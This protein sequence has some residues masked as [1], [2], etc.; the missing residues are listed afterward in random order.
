MGLPSDVADAFE[1]QRGRAT[2]DRQRES[3]KQVI[4]QTTH[5]LARFFLEIDANHKQFQVARKLREQGQIRLDRARASFEE[6]KADTSVDRLLDAIVQYA[7]AV[8]QEAQ[9]KCSYNTSLA[10]LE[11]AKGTLLAERKILVV[12]RPRESAAKAAGVASTPRLVESPPTGIF[13][14]D[15]DVKPAAFAAPADATS[16]PIAPKADSPAPSGRVIRYDIALEGGPVPVQ[17]KGT[18]S[19]GAPGGAERADVAARP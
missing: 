7:D 6:G 9:Y 3:L 8:V 17:L 12:A 18:V 16:E 15:L 19:F 14:I 4:H 10:A 13:G 1:A 2:V 11:E 5:S